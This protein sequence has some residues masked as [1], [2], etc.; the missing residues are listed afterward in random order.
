M[1]QLLEQSTER[2]EDICNNDL[3][4]VHDCDLALFNFDGTELDSGTVVEFMYAK[5]LDKPSVILL[6][7][8]RSGG[9][10]QRGE[11]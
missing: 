2:S 3:K 6:S 7:D 5:F 10:Q 9:D 8:F 4:Q 1:P 11:Q